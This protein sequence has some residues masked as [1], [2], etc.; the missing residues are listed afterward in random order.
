MKN[1]NLINFVRKHPNPDEKSPFVKLHEGKVVK[2]TSLC[3]L[4]RNDCKKLSSDRIRRVMALKENDYVNNKRNCIRNQVK[5]KCSIYQYKPPKK[6][7]L[8]KCRLKS[9]AKYTN[10][11]NEEK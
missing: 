5:I 10:I 11:S 7:I 3:W 9:F 8:K 2:K 4:L 6:S 1:A